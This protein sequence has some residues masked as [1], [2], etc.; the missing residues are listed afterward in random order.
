MR[1]SRRRAEG[2]R[3]MSADS[4]RVPAATGRGRAALESALDAITGPALI[5]DQLG[6]VVNANGAARAL[7]E[8]DG[9]GIKSSLAAAVAGHSHEPCWDLKPLQTTERPLGFLALLK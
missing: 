3:L 8:R 1:R 6:V 7:L 2:R 5:V 9:K 4:R